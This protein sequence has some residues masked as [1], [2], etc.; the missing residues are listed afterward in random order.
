MDYFLC[1]QT[2]YTF[3]I[4]ALGFAPTVGTF[5]L[6]FFLLYIVYNEALIAENRIGELQ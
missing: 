6:L 1:Q 3:Y 5:A 4:I 2:I